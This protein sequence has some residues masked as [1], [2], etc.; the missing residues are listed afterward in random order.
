MGETKASRRIRERY[1]PGFRQTL[2]SVCPV[3]C[4]VSLVMLHDR[5]EDIFDEK[6]GSPA[7][8]RN[9]SDQQEEFPGTQHL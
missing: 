1:V 5:G 8:A 4:L 2:A 6:K 7:W 3:R 9:W